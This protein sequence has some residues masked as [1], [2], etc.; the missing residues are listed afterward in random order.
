MIFANLANRPDVYAF[1]GVFQNYFKLGSVVFE[2]VEDGSDGYR[3]YLETIALASPPDTSIFFK[4]PI[5]YVA[6]RDGDNGYELYSPDTDHIWLTVGTEYDDSG[7]YPCF[8]F[9]YTPD[10]RQRTLPTTDLCPRDIHPEL[11]I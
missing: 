3:S 7:Y 5:A 1:Y 6:I 9:R 10:K 8:I 4:Q 11:F 2:A